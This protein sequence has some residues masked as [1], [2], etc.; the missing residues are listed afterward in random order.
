MQRAK[1]LKLSPIVWARKTRFHK[2]VTQHPLVRVPAN[3]YE[4]AKGDS[5]SERQRSLAIEEAARLTSL[6]P[7][8]PLEIHYDLA[9]ESQ[10]L[11]ELATCLFLAKYLARAKFPVKFLLSKTV[12]GGTSE[13]SGLDT[14]YARQKELESLA[15][16]MSKGEFDLIIDDSMSSG[17]RVSDPLSHKVFEQ[18]NRSRTPI[19]HATMS[20]FTI[21]E[22]LEKFGDADNLFAWKPSGYIGWH[23]R[24]SSANS[25]RNYWNDNLL[26]EDAQ[27]LA[28]NFPDLEI[29]V[30]T[31]DSG[32]QKLKEVASRRAEFEK[33]LSQGII[34]FQRAEDFAGAATESAGCNFWFQR[35]GGGIAVFPTFSNMP[36]LILSEDYRVR[37]LLAFQGASLFPWHKQSQSWILSPDAA[38]KKFPTRFLASQESRQR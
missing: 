9:T 37:N 2:A 34:S 7:G 22:F 10:N 4:K 24:S 12:L 1:P 16:Q 20:I 19:I 33:M 31:D 15:K 5:W 21:P 25:A 26:V 36:F 13:F 38:F 14:C 23:I 27:A 30:F 28:G 6:K 3:L 32:R 29:R 11:G 17:E 18:L 8:T 35:L